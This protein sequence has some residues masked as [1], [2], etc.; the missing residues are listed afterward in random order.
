MSVSP[1]PQTDCKR[2]I[3]LLMVKDLSA[4]VDF[5][6]NKLG[7]SHVF[8]WGKPPELAGV[9]LGEVSVHLSEGG[10]QE[11]AL[12]FVIEDADEMYDF[13]VSQGVDI[14]FPPGDRP[15]EL[16]DYAVRDPWGNKLSFGHYIQ[17]KEP[18]LPIERV[19][20]PVRLEKRLAALLTDLAAYKGMTIGSCLEETLL[21]TFEVVGKDEG[22]ASPHTKRT[23]LYIQELKKK[24]GI[25]YDT[26]ASYRF[27]E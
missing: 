22:V 1:V 8:T 25:D 5:Y 6:A 14:M 13:H 9:N 4:A 16:R 23:H 10:P 7:F 17:L 2:L 18:K 12:Y 19:E 11:N 3:P 27:E 21:H 20:V 24:H 15:Y 26:H